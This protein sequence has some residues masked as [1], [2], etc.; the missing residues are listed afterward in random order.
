[1]NK[2]TRGWVL[3][4]SEA[5]IDQALQSMAANIQQRDSAPR[6]LR[7]RADERADDVTR[8]RRLERRAWTALDEQAE[9]AR[10]FT[11]RPERQSVAG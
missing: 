3:R 6:R 7:Y 11:S 8:Y 4:A 2:F 1:M 9:N 5:T 10:T